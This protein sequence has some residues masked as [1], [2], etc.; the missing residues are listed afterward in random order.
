MHAI[1]I[2]SSVAAPARDIQVFDAGKVLLQSGRTFRNMPDVGS[3]YPNVTCFDAVQVQRRML[4]DLW[5]IEQV[6]LVYG[7]SM[8]AIQAYHWAALFPKAVERIAVVCGAARCAPHN[9]VFIEGVK[10][11]PGL[12]RC[13][14][15]YLMHRMT[16]LRA[17]RQRG[18]AGRMLSR[19]CPP[20]PAHRAAR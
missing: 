5:D 4:E 14:T 6:A 12:A 20:R 8:G 17:D 7:W 19:S 15:C 9:R 13:R 16:R 11:A 18:V 2:G 10:H 1:S 3:R